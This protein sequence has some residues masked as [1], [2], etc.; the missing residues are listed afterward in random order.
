MNEKELR[1]AYLEMG[2]KFWASV[3]RGFA[4]FGVGLMIIGFGLAAYFWFAKE[5]A[6]AFWVVFGYLIL[7]GVV[8][9]WISIGTV[10]ELKKPRARALPSSH[11]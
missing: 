9:A 5:H 7:H 2:V 11:A 1:L 3:L 6:G 10:W 4:W 8:G